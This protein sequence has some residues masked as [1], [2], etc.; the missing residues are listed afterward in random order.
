MNATALLLPQTSQPSGAL[1]SHIRALPILQQEFA[2]VKIG[3][4]VYVIERAVNE[5][6]GIQIK[7]PSN[8]TEPLSFYKKDAANTLIKKR[9]V[10]L[11]TGEKQSTVLEQWWTDSNTHVYDTIACSPIAQPPNVINMWRAA[12]LQPMQGEWPI[13]HEYLFEVLSGG[14]VAVYEYSLDYIAHALQHPEEK[15]EVLIVLIGGQGSGKSTFFKIFRQIWGA[16][17][18]QTS[19]IGDV[20]GDFNAALERSY[21]VLLDEA[22]FYGDRKVTESLKSII[23]EPVITIQAKH[24]PQRQIE[25]FHR[26]VAT[27]NHARFGS[28]EMDDRRYVPLEV[29]NTKVGDKPYWTKV[30][31]AI[32]GN[33]MQALMYD[34]LHRDI[35]GFHPRERPVTDELV[36]QKIRSLQGFASVWYEF[37]QD[38]RVSYEEWREGNFISTSSLLDIWEKR[39]HKERIHGET[40]VTVIHE[41]IKKLCPSMFACRARVEGSQQ[42]GFNLPSL[43]QARKD[44]EGALG[45]KIDWGN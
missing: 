28:V 38:G 1:V 41:A 44:F 30:N 4:G 26:Y 9:I 37:L 23:T 27:T 3:G 12:T 43:A 15:S 21:F 19:R 13:L 16:N 8:P 6:G 32:A 20:T 35:R 34:L 36:L 5:L 7:L 42:R 29:S 39:G 24:Q 14:R 10:S 22:V 17:S 18:F 31:S 25:S 11:A 45:G 33:E 2:M 40:K